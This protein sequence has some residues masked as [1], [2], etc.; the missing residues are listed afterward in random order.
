[1]AGELI[2]VVEDD[3]KSR[4]LVRDILEHEGYRVALASTGL[5]GLRLAQELQPRLVVM[6]I[7]LPGLDGISVLQRIRESAATR[8]MLVVAV[9]ASAMPEDRSK[10]ESA[11]FDGYQ[12][13]PIRVLEFARA[14]HDLIA[15][16]PHPRVSSR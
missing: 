12:H 7:Q 6:D 14:V 2:L 10:I 13:K 8:A 16:T 9:T 1:M 11:G 5:D 3:E 4:R 15:A